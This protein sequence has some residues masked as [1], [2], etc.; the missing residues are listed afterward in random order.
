M[1][2]VSV[3][4]PTMN[5]EASIGICI[6]KIQKVFAEYQIDGEIIVA[7]NSTDRTPVIAESLG[8]RVVVPDKLGY[9]YAYRYGFAQASGDYIVIGDADNTY[10]FADIPRLLE[11]LKRDEADLVMGSRFKGDILKGAMPWLHKHIGNPLLTWCVNK[12]NGSD[13]S[14]CHSG[15]RAFTKRAYDTM[16]LTTDGME[17][18]SEM[19][20][21]ALTCGLRIVEIPITYYP[22]V[23][24]SEPN[25]SSFSDGWRHLKFILLDAPTHLFILPGAILGI[26]GVLTVFLI[27]A[28]LNLWD[29]GLGIHSMI[30]GCLLTIVGY[31]VVFLGLFAKIYGVRHSLRGHDR[32][33]EFI[34]AHLSLERV[35]MMGLAIFFTGCTFILCLFWNWAKSGYVNLPLVE[36]DIVLLTMVVIGLQTIFYSF[37]LSVIA[38]EG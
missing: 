25:L 1:V 5:E 3:V 11:P 20:M 30:A 2:D 27:W 33:T 35:V 13:I 32:T 34:A 36:H 4:I 21:R 24:G 38:G 18:A 22:R 6:E 31:Q 26:V 8:V 7:D 37:F 23:A 17:F 28:P 15:F 10:D 19:I 29:T 16:G 14:D 9:G 12:T